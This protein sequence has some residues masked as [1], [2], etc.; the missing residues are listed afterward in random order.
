MIRE[1]FMGLSILVLMLPLPVMI[2]LSMVGYNGAKEGAGSVLLLMEIVGIV[3]IF[4]W[5]STESKIKS[6]KT[7]ASE[8]KA[9]EDKTVP[10]SKSAKTADA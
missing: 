10:A 6:N 1:I 7:T 4:F 3:L 2:I 9:S 8:N 5:N